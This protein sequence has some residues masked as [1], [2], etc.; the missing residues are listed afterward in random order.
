MCMKRKHAPDNTQPLPAS[1]WLHTARGEAVEVGAE[2]MGGTP[3]LAGKAMAH[4]VA[5]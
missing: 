5:N 3:T 1:A 4:W 2:E